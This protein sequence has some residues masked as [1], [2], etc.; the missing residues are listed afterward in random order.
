MIGAALKALREIRDAQ[1]RDT[2]MIPKAAFTRLV[3]EISD[4][5]AGPGKDLRWQRSAIE[6]L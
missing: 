3:K 2:A 5:I 4:D 6:G 1:Y